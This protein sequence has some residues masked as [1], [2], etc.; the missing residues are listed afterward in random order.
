MV[1][2]TYALVGYS[3]TVCVANSLTVNFSL[4]MSMLAEMH[5]VTRCV[6]IEG[7]SVKRCQVALR[8]GSS[9]QHQASSIDIQTASPIGQLMEDMRRKDCI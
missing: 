9:R 3:V 8:Y 7:L 5:K 4:W 2:T 6:K 1:R